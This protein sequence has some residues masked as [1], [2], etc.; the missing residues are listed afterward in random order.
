MHTG[1]YSDSR[2]TIAG[3]ETSKGGKGIGGSGEQGR[4]FVAR[5]A[6]NNLYA[7]RDGNVYRHDDDGWS[8]YKEG[9]WEQVD[10]P[11]RGEGRTPPDSAAR[12]E[13]AA[14]LRERA[15]PGERGAGVRDRESGARPDSPR[16]ADRGSRDRSSFSQLER[17]RRARSSGAARARDSRSWRSGGAR[18]RPSSFGGRGGF[19]GRR[20]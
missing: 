3:L 1:H 7:G 6:D 13:R 8:Q 19:R 16:L 18:S 5:D 20:R 9:G 4:G 10:P 14:Q 11:E 15:A 17:D 2:G 12:E